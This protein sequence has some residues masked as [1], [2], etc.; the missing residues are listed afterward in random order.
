MFENCSVEIYIKFQL[1]EIL[2]FIR[3]IFIQVNLRSKSSKFLKTYK[4]K[5]Y[6]MCVLC[7]LV[8]VRSVNG[9]ILLH[10]LFF[11]LAIS[12]TPCN[13]IICVIIFVQYIYNM[14]LLI[15]SFLWCIIRKKHFSVWSPLFDFIVNFLR[16]GSFQ[17]LRFLSF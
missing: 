14:I 11:H 4:S 3:R 5:K 12:A 10:G 7:Y 2:P 17:K 9:Y 1:I 8:M 15:Q 16:V 13:K 6:S